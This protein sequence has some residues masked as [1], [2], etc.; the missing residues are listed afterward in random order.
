MHVLE[1]ASN[2]E[3]ALQKERMYI[4]NNECVNT[5]NPVLIQGE[6]R[7]YLNEYQRIY[8]QANKEKINEYQREYQKVNREK[9]TQQQRDR[10]A[11]KKLSND[12]TDDE[13][14]P[15]VQGPDDGS[16]HACQ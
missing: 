1:E 7:K 3:E 12:R 11:K 14:V 15:C 10:R 8:Y 4:Q 2:K 16:R 6:R 9:L 5:H 13:H